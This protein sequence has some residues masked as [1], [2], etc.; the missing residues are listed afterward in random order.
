M[1]KVSVCIPV[2][3]VEPYIQKCTQS[4]LN[5][6]IDSLELIFVDD[7]SP[8]RSIEIVENEVAEYRKSHLD[9]NVIRKIKIIRFAENHGVSAARKA[10]INAATG[11]YIIHC[12]PDDWVEQA[13]YDTMYNQ[14]RKENSDVIMCGVQIHRVDNICETYFP[15]R[16]LLKQDIIKKTLN[17]DGCI[18]TSLWAKMFKTSIQQQALDHIDESIYIGEDIR[19][20]IIAL[21]VCSK[22]SC[23][24]SIFYHYVRRIDSL[25]TTC[26][27]KKSILSEIANYNF[28]SL[29]LPFEYQDQIMNNKKRIFYESILHNSLSNNEYQNLFPE[30]R[31][32]ALLHTKSPK[33]W[34]LLA[35]SFLSYDWAVK[36][37]YLIEK[38][39]KALH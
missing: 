28:Y 37:N 35:V 29:F 23:I 9:T 4:L 2:Y 32:F 22:F 33:L 30:I 13:A 5:Q 18:Y 21:S 3:K 15:E 6:T 31:K 25:I 11:E 34:I 10:A 27:N 26:Y 36:L 38:I 16:G 8:D 20:N 7:A 1:I 24:E 39:R 17:R 14:G 12:D 19:I